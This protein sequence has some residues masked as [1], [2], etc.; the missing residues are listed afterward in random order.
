MEITA[1]K[2]AVPSVAEIF[3]TMEYGPAPEADNVAQAWFEDHERSFGH[4]INNEWLKPDGRQVTNVISPA[5]G[6]TMATTL[7]GTTEDVDTA[8][9]AA[10]DAYGSWSQ[11]SGHARARHLYSIA[12]HVQ[13]HHRLVAVVEALDNGKSIRETR[14]ADIPIVIRHLY[15]YAGW[16][17]KVFQIIFVLDTILNPVYTL[18]VD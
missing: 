3:A 1:K 4:F 17:G 10:T 18:K 5:D 9:K 13:K 15:H 8:V 16:A 7:K 14:D 12:R 11:L 6:K 2:V